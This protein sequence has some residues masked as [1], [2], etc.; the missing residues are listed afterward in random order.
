MPQQANNVTI[1]RKNPRIGS[2]AATPA[3]ELLDYSGKNSQVR[4]S[5]ERKRFTVLVWIAVR[6]YLYTG[7]FTR[8][9][10]GQWLT[11]IASEEEVWKE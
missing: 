5:L 11:A 2:I 1:A 4:I 6:R 3:E 7:A 9:A 10:S 8:D